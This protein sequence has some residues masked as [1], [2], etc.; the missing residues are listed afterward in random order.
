MQ[1]V[2]EGLGVSFSKILHAIGL[3]NALDIEK[4]QALNYAKNACLIKVGYPCEVI[5]G[6]HKKL[7]KIEGL[8]A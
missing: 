5:G 6:P 1:V 7:R 3:A 4:N 2:L 8:K